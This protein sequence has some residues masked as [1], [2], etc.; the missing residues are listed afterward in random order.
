MNTHFQSGVFIRTMSSTSKSG[1]IPW[2][3]ER[4]GERVG[5]DSYETKGWENGGGGGE[6]DGGVKE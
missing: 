5:E 2:F 4:A 6:G 3:L 1:A